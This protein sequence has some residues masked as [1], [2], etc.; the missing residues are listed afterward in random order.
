MCLHVMIQRNKSRSEGDLELGKYHFVSFVDMC[1]MFESV[2][3]I[4]VMTSGS[5]V[6]YEEG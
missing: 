4:P 1:Q 6:Q 3:D 2:I 5:P